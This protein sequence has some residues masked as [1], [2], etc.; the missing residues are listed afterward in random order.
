MVPV[1]ADYIIFM[2][3]G[4]LVFPDVLSKPFIQTF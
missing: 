1:F 4:L 2:T 3:L